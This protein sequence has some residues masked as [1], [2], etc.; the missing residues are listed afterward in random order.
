MMVWVQC[1]WYILWHSCDVQN[2]QINTK[3]FLYLKQTW[4]SWFIKPTVHHWAQWRRILP[5]WWLS[6]SLVSQKHFL[7][8]PWQ[9][10]SWFCKNTRDFIFFVMTKQSI[11]FEQIQC[12]ANTDN[13]R[14]MLGHTYCSYMFNFLY[15]WAKIKQ[16]NF[17]VRNNILLLAARKWKNMVLTTR[18]IVPILWY[19]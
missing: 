14:T 7:P 19:Q 3:N 6:V 11:L 2:W 5:F 4:L 10:N 1:T 18:K 12:N 15:F 9:K 17:T 13:S 16:V 8:H